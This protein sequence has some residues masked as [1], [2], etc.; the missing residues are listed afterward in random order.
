MSTKMK[1][2]HPNLDKIS[3]VINYYNYELLRYIKQYAIMK[4]LKKKIK[5]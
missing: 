2:E 5:N 1:H 3:T 4:A